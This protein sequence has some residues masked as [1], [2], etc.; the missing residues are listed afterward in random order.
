MDEDTSSYEQD[1]FDL[2][3]S[4]RTL[5]VYWYLLTQDKPRTRRQVKDEVGLSSVSLAGYHLKKLENM[6]LAKDNGLGEYFVTRSVQVGV[7]RFYM[8]MKT[9]LIPRFVLYATFYG[10]TLVCLLL[11]VS[12]VSPTSFL[13]MVLVLVFGVITS[14]F[15]VQSLARSKQIPHERSET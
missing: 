4:G 13:L 3:L 5:W 8:R 12:S 2:Q 10:G 6:G 1:D 9:I 11:F 15:E 7:L 14:L